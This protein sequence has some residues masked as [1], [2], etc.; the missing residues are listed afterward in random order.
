MFQ[1]KEK[2]ITQFQEDGYLMVE[3]L[4]DQEEMDLLLQIGKA[5][6]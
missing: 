5:D 6:Q 2:H 1:L 4:Y 3:G